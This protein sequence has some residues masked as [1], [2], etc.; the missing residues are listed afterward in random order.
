MMSIE[1]GGDCIF[2]V[3]LHLFSFRA[4]TQHDV[5]DSF[6]A[7]LDDRGQEGKRIRWYISSC[8]FSGEEI[9]ELDFRFRNNL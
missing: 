5:V 4:I 7:E 2:V 9:Q 1:E 8:K 6:E 3:I